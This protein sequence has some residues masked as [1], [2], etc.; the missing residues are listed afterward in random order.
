MDIPDKN[1]NGT[2]YITLTCTYDGFK[3]GRCLAGKCNSNSEYLSNNCY[4]NRCIFS[5]ETPIDHC[6]NI[7]S[8]NYI[9]NR[10]SSYMHCGKPYGS[11]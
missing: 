6:E 3:S 1:G 11:P 9:L 5:E 2:R 4:E 8:Y 10:R 7:Y